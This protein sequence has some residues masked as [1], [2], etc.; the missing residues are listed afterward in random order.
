MLARAPAPQEAA[1]PEVEQAELDFAIPAGHFFTQSTP[2]RDGRGFSVFDGHG[3]RLWTAY[4]DAGGF[5]R[6]GYPLSRRFAIGESVGQAFQYGRLVWDEET[7]TARVDEASNALPLEAIQPELPPLASG[8][9]E[10]R[11]WSGWWWPA[12]E[13]LGPTLFRVRGPLDTYDRYV[14]AMTGENPG[15]RAWE[16]REMYFPDSE[17]AGHCNGWAAAAL[18]EPEPTEV[19]RLGDLAFGVGDQKGLL[20]TYYFAAA[21]AWTYGQ[22]DG[23][24]AADFHRVLLEWMG[25]GRQGFVVTFDLGG[26]EVWSYPAYRFES[27]WSADPRQAAIWQV[28]TTVWMAD[29]EVP[30][31][32]IGTRPFPSPSGKVFEYTLVGDPRSPESG[33]WSGRSAGRTPGFSRPGLVWYPEPSVRNLDRELA[34]PDL[35]LAV[36]REIAAGGPPEGSDSV[37]TARR[38]VAEEPASR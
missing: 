28:R 9:A 2:D 21:A 34:S 33:E 17:W 10:V 3:A 14:E 22:P 18:L 5:A 20:S 31:D 6:L 32:F 11:P 1:E 35:E 27:A 12:F 16:R 15:T 4:G 26:G 29:M 23:L 13:G 25:S 30:P 38:R 7:G 8:E 36:I 37:A 24:S 19:V